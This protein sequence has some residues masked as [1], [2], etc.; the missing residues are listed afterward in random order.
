MDTLLEYMSDKFHKKTTEDLEQIKFCEQRI[1]HYKNII[2]AVKESC[3]HLDKEVISEVYDVKD[4]RIYKRCIVC[5]DMSRDVSIEEKTKAVKEHLDDI[6]VSY[7]TE[8]LDSI[9]KKS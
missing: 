8:E 3:S 1:S 5:G 4:L 9:I 2:K 7:T 6:E